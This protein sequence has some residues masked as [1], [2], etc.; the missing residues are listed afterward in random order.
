MSEPTRR[1]FL[2][3]LAA[4]P[5]SIKAAFHNV[6][7]RENRYPLFEE[8]AEQ[9]DSGELDVSSKY[10]NLTELM[11]V[12]GVR[13]FDQ[14]G[15]VL[16]THARFDPNSEWGIANATSTHIGEVVSGGFWLP[17]E[18]D[19]FTITSFELLDSE[20]RILWGPQPVDYPRLVNSGDTAHI[21]LTVE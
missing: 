2:G 16:T 21:E 6:G 20:G 11:S 17:A 13:F 3:V 5:L 14:R 18:L 4:V 8:A 19:G 9:I 12:T 7:R 1:G 15:E 10:E